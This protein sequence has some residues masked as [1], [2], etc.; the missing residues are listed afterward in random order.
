VV[1]F[2]QEV[3]IS[4]S[5]VHVI[6]DFL[7]CAIGCASRLTVSMFSIMNIIIIPL[8]VLISPLI[9]LISLLNN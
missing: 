2:W 6:S 8:I 5:I 9:V 1:V 3:L 4:P 7:D